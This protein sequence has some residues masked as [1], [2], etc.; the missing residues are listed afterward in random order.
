MAEFPKIETCL[1][2][3][4]AREE[5]G[6]KL[7]LLGFYGTAPKV[8]ITISDPTMPVK[9][10]L[11]FEGSGGSGQ[12]NGSVDLVDVDGAVLATTPFSL[13]VDPQKS[14]SIIGAAFSTILPQGEISTVVRY[15]GHA[16]YQSAFTIDW[17]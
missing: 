9:V 5:I 13:Y 14:K 7:T 4:G 8:R 1:V 3:E 12:I 11:L 6:H 2:C 17:E 16:V 15:E 10:L